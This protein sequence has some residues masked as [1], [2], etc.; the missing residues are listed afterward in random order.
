M[1]TYDNFPFGDDFLQPALSSYANSFVKQEGVKLGTQR[2]VLVQ[3]WHTDGTNDAAEKQW[4]D[5]FG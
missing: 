2:E 1:T 5:S 4:A 3:S